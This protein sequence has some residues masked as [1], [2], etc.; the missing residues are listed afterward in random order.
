MSG[1]YLWESECVLLSKKTCFSVRE[2]ICE[3][4]KTQMDSILNA[5]GIYIKLKGN[6]DANKFSYGETCLFTKQNTQAFWWCQENICENQSV[7]CL[8]KR[9]VSP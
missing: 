6:L 8:V 7:F 2:F 9:H 4:N 3:N 5:W 1:K